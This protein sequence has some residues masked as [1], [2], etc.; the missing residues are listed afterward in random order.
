M[1]LSYV[2]AAG[3]SLSCLAGPALAHHPLNGL[4]M[5]TF[6]HGLL[7]GVGHPIL[8]FEHLF[9]VLAMGAAAALAGL[10]WRGSLAYIATMTAGSLLI[11]L[12]GSLPIQQGLIAVSVVALGALIASQRH[13]PKLL[14]IFMFAAFGLFHGAAFG[15]ALAGQ[16]GTAPL[17]VFLGYLLGLGV[18]QTGLALMAGL[19]VTRVRPITTRLGGAMVA[20]AGILLWLEYIEGLVFS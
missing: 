9:F 13:A 18:T 6:T 19:L 10:L 4:P 3:V 2:L 16:E 20:G 11:A 12:G 8:G 7:S 5:E 14:L 17:P 15:E 1:R